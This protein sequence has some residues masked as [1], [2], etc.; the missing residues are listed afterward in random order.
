M[1]LDNDDVAFFTF[2]RVGDCPTPWSCFVIAIRNEVLENHPIEVKKVLDII[3]TY[4]SDFKKIN[5][6]DDCWCAGRSLDRS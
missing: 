5:A 4:T 3:N 1:N 2:R 6:I